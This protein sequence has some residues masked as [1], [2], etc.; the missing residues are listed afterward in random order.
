LPVG[1]HVELVIEWPNRYE[2]AYPVELLATGFIVRSEGGRT[3]VR[4]TSR[5][6]RVDQAPAQSLRAT[7]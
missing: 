1:A 2:D 4:V 3:A 7:A 6:L 5:K